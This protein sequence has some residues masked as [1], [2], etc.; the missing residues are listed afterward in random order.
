[1]LAQVQQKGP[2]VGGGC[3]SAEIDG[4]TED[5]SWCAALTWKDLTCQLGQLSLSHFVTRLIVFLNYQ[6][7]AKE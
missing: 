6:K 5:R 1:M 2:A 3:S 4:S 7:G